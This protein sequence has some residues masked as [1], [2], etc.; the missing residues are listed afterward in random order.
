MTIVKTNVPMTS[1]L[2]HETVLALADRYP[3]I[4]TAVLTETAFGRPVDR[5]ADR[6]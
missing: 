3:S 2:S 4:Q 6:A 5:T 1:Q